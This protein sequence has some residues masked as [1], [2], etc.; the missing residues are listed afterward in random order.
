MVNCV[1]C[2][3]ECSI[4]DSL[5][6]FEHRRHWQMWTRRNVNPWAFTKIKEINYDGTVNM[7]INKFKG[8]YKW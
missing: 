7:L 8:D 1:I 6:C 4:G 3:Q 2:G 5:F